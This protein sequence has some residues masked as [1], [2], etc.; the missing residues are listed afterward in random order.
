MHIINFELPSCEYA[1]TLSTRMG[2]YARLPAATLSAHLFSNH[3]LCVFD[4]ALIPR[5][6]IKKKCGLCP[7][8]GGLPRKAPRH[9]RM[10]HCF[11]HCR[12]GPLHETKCGRKVRRNYRSQLH[13][14]EDP[15]VLLSPVSSLESENI[16]SHHKRWNRSCLERPTPLGYRLSDKP[17]T[18]G[19]SVVRRPE[20]ASDH[21]YT[22]HLTLELDRV[23]LFGVYIEIWKGPQPSTVKM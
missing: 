5:T 18:H 4:C 14:L 6:H 15:F 3:V 16:R 13:P 11:G 12:A 8:S 1:H 2:Q 17:G 22:P 7:D 10:R 19:G 9:F 20:E 21:R 23:R